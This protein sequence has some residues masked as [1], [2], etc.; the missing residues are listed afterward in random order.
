MPSLV[1]AERLEDRADVRRVNAMAFGR[2]DEADLVD[3]LRDRCPGYLGLVALEGD[4]VIGHIAFSP[5]DL[6]GASSRALVGLAPMA[7]HPEHQQR[8]VGT[9]LVSDGLEAARDTG[10]DAV[11]VLGHPGYYPRFGFEVVGPA[12]ENEYGGPP[13]AFMVVELTSGVLEGVSGT[14]RYHPAF[15]G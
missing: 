4:Q 14:V 2:P 6:G 8:G 3:R 7:V 11:F 10:A 15:A 1:R 5:I 9:A 12:I 13:E